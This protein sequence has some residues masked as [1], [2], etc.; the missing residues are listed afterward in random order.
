M[1]ISFNINK[2]DNN[3]Y[4]FKIL[5]FN[6]KFIE[7]IEKKKII[8]IL[9]ND[10]KIKIPSY[11]GWED[12]VISNDKFSFYVSDSW[13]RGNHINNTNIIKEYDDKKESKQYAMIHFIIGRSQVIKSDIEDFD[14]IFIKA[15]KVLSET[16]NS[17][18]RDQLKD[19]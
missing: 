1:N 15:M 4:N 6:D 12:C 5:K 17:Y 14:K 16:Y 7:F 13:R 8:H 2:I 18:I 11:T 9:F 19:I 3:K 10:K